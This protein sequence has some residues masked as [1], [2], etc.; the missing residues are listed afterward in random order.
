M[1]TS[2]VSP[3]PGQRLSPGFAGDPLA[4]RFMQQPAGGPGLLAGTKTPAGLGFAPG[5]LTPG[6]M[7]PAVGGSPPA[8][9]S[10]SPSINLVNYTPFKIPALDTGNLR[11]LWSDE[12]IN[13]TANRGINQLSVAAADAIRDLETRLA[14]TGA[15]GAL[16]EGARDIYTGTGAAA[17]GYRGDV[18][19]AARQDN[20]RHRLEQLAQRLQEREQTLGALGE[21]GRQGLMHRGQGLD[22][23][24]EQGRQRLTELGLN[25]DLESEAGRQGLQRYLGELGA[26]TTGRGQDIDWLKSQLD[27]LVRNRGL[28]ISQREQDMDFLLR[29]RDQDIR[30]RGDTLGLMGQREARELGWNQSVLDAL[31]RALGIQAQVR[32]QDMDYAATTNRQGQED[33]WRQLQ[34]MLSLAQFGQQM[35]GSE[36]RWVSPY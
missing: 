2:P 21:Q 17:A 29:G 11:D 3:M 30:G 34:M 19:Q 7:T 16:A 12:Q 5:Q 20:A 14:G 28:D 25:F 31:A 18:E 35:G 4:R 26:H 23:T 6:R 10:R 1:F 15:T 27:A 24:S 8:S 13:R 36:N 9:A 22:F 33:L 32:G